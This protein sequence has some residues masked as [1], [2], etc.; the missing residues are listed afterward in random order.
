MTIMDMDIDPA[1]TASF[2][3]Q[4]AVPC[5]SSEDQ[6]DILAFLLLH[7]SKEASYLIQE[8]ASGYFGT[9]RD[10]SS[11]ERKKNKKDKEK[12]RYAKAMR[13]LS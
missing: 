3:S 4:V 13:R 11:E 10:S 7:S 1:P 9:V 8:G 2:A 12:R 5:I 6:T